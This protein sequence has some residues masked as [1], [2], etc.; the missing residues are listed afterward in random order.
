MAVQALHPYFTEI[1]QDKLRSLQWKAFGC[2]TVEKVC[3]VALVAIAAAVLAI[4]LGALPLLEAGSGWLVLMALSPLLLQPIASSFKESADGYKEQAQ[5][6]ERVVRHLGLIS[7]WSTAHIEQFF[8]EEGLNPIPNLDKSFLPLI[9][10]F[11]ALNEMGDKAEQEANKQLGRTNL[12]GLPRLRSRY[13]GWDYHERQ[14]IPRKFEA[15]R[16]LQIIQSPF[17]NPSLSERGH[18][19]QKR[20]D[21]RMEG[22]HYQ[23]I[24]DTY[25]VFDRSLNRSPLTLEQI[26]DDMKPRT[27]RPLLFL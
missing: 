12:K 18:Y 22:R 24:N 1:P 14:A 5:I 6:E 15:A 9:A 26:E 2:E 4:S 17:S 7:N 27:L 21:E 23:P 25:F 16:L 19:R 11:Y 10:R 8:R 3:L 20:F 13:I